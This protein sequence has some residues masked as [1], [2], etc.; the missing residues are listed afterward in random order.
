MALGE[1]VKHF[2]SFQ[3]ANIWRTEA[4]RTDA[5]VLQIDAT[6]RHYSRCNVN[7]STNP[8]PTSPPHAGLW[9][10]RSEADRETD[11][12]LVLS[13]VG[14]TRW[15]V[16]LQQRLSDAES[17]QRASDLKY[18]MDAACLNSLPPLQSVD[19]E[20]W[21]SGGDWTSRLCGQPADVL[22]RE[23]GASPAHSGSHLHEHELAESFS[24]V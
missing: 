2:R 21:G 7:V 11:D 13:F 23:C 17:I 4:H 24:S 8:T 14:Q 22:L 19:A 20:R 1:R 16:Y 9:P 15:V 18:L 12:M 6:W 10:L 5:F 3:R